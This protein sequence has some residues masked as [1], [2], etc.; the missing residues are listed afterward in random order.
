MTCFDEEKLKEAK[1]S[2]MDSYVDNIK[3]TVIF[4]VDY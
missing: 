4:D 3:T 2:I 1:F